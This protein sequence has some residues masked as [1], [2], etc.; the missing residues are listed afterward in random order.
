MYFLL[1]SITHILSIFYILLST[2]ERH[3]FYFLLFNIFHYMLYSKYNT[4]HCVLLTTIHSIGYYSTS[5]TPL[6]I[7]EL[8]HDNLLMRC[9]S[10]TK[11]TKI[12]ILSNVTCIVKATTKIL[13]IYKAKFKTYK[14]YY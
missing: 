6:S 11:L 10:K 12:A 1:L 13:Q 5:Y 7:V 9:K 8:S 3:S 14:I 2:S 4:F